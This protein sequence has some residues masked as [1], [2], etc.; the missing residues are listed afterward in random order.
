MNLRQAISGARQAGKAW[1]SAQLESDP[2]SD[3]VA[4]QIY[5]AE[6]DPE[7]HWLV[8]SKKDALRAATNMLGDYIVDINRD[9]DMHEL[10]DIA[11]KAGVS[12]EDRDAI[13][14]AVGDGIRDVIYS[15]SAK[16]WLA[17][18]ILFRSREAQGLE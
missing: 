9:L 5:A 2:F 1:A 8:R 4:D 3:Y 11:R 7:N 18:E 17:D 16:A 6:K 12:H 13:A 14:S 10:Y 15:K